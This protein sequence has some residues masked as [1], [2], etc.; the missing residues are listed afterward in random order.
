[1][2][3]RTAR[4]S[5]DVP[6]HRPSAENQ[7]MLNRWISRCVAQQMTAVN[8]WSLVERWI[9][10]AFLLFSGGTRRWGKHLWAS[11]PPNPLA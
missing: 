8:K 1:M 7:L 11:T 3:K 10:V 4:I 2:A 9:H 6:L 5:T